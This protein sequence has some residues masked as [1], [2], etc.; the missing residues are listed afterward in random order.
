LIPASNPKF[1]VVVVVNDPSGKDYYGGLVAAPVF[2]RMMEGALRVMNVPPD[3]VP[4]LL[5]ALPTRVTTALAPP[6]VDNGLLPA[7]AESVPDNVGLLP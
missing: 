5:A 2:G 7:E 6:G 1:S 4:G 3:D